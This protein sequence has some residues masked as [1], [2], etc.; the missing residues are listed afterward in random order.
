MQVAVATATLA[1]FDQNT[2]I[3]S[4]PVLAY[5][6]R[7]HL[8][9]SNSMG[10]SCSPMGF[11]DSGVQVFRDEDESSGVFPVDLWRARCRPGATSRYS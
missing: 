1:L 3:A 10:R 6:L 2:P 7:A 5:N 4:S 8:A 9:I 11:G